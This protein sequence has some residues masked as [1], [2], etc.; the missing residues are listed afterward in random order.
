MDDKFFL[1]VLSCCM[2]KT[3]LERGRST[4]RSLLLL[5]ELTDQITFATLR[6]LVTLNF[7]L[8]VKM[9]VITW[10]HFQTS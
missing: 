7:H 1:R 2:H 4:Y 10:S 6:T 3:R 8:K 9:L 5:F